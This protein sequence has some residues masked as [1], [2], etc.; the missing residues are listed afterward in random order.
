MRRV[1]EWFLEPLN[2]HAREIFARE[3]DSQAEAFEKRA[4]GRREPIFVWQ[5]S[6]RQKDFYVRSRGV[7]QLQFNVWTAF[8]G[9]LLR[10]W[11]VDTERQKKVG[12]IRRKI[13]AIKEGKKTPG[14]I[15]K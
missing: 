5:C 7:S 6:E 14:L 13:Q 12:K 8:E 11:P 3:I 1:R 9:E 4:F 10:I 2:S 15:A